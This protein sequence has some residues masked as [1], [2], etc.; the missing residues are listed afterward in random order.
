MGKV[1]EFRR[2]A[3]D[4][5]ELVAA[6]SVADVGVN[7]SDKPGLGAFGKTALSVLLRIAHTLLVLVWP[8]LKW[9][10]ASFSVVKAVSA[11]YHWN[12]PASNA[13]WQF[14]GY[15]ALLVVLTWL[16]SHYKMAKA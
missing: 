3:K 2:E 15:F 5:V 7:A 8:F 16:V 12:D 11:M 13:G 1:I 6:P 14:L 9:V 10:L 4:V